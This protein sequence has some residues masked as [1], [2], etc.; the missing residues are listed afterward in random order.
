MSRKAR[1]EIAALY[2]TAW[3]DVKAEY[4]WLQES[5]GKG[6]KTPSCSP[7]YALRKG[8]KGFVPY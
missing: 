3:E 1:I 7:P 6:Y 4:S 2:P 8:E 5:A